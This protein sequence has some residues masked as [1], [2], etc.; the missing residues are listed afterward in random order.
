MNSKTALITGASTGIG[1][2]LTRLFAKNGYNLVLIA[3]NK[4]KLQKAANT[5]KSDFNITPKIIDKDLSFPNAANDIYNELKSSNIE[6]D[7]LVNDA[8]C[9]VY[10]EFAKN[11]ITQEINMLQV[12][13]IFPTQLTKLFLP[14]MIK[15]GSGKILNVSSVGAFVPG[16]L[17]DVYCAS[18]AYMLSFSEGL[19]EELVGTGVT[20]TALCPGATDSEFAKT[21]HIENTSLF[22]GHLSDAK[23]VAK[24]GYDALMKGKRV[25]IPGFYNRTI[26]GMTKLMPR[27]WVARF[28][29]RS[30]SIKE[31]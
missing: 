4:E 29:K 18:K 28:A 20:V 19:A 12:N 10:G 13:A 22:E 27:T 14:N 25:V 3:K 11:D 2:Q 16:P 31:K 30:M 9:Q 26:M 7:V 21:A 23:Q 24:A 8:G 5:I 6:I 1:Y 17:N 15:K